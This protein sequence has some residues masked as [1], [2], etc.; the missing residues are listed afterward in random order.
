[1]LLIVF[2]SLCFDSAAKLL[3]QSGFSTFLQ[4][5]YDLICHKSFAITGNGIN[6]LIRIYKAY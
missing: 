5:L 4:P 2:F 1:M 3:Q 6:I